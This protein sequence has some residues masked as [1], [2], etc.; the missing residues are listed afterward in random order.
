MTF[1]PNP[2]QT[3]SIVRW[4]I[5]AFGAGVAGWFAHGGFVTQQQVM[6]VLN[7]PAFL[8]IATSLVGLVWG[9]KA[10]T[11]T[12]TVAAANAIPEVQ[13]VIVASTTA[14]MALAQSIPEKSVAVAGTADATAVAARPPITGL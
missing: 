14:G 4:L 7:S 11:Q 2:E 1:T 12:S 9:M 10:H 3:K 5:T 8:S 6:D 13:G